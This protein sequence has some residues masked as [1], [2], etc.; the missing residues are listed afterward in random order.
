MEKEA[1]TAHSGYPRSLALAN[2]K[3]DFLD[4]MFTIA[5]I[6]V[7]VAGCDASDGMVVGGVHPIGITD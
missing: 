1:A 2:S 7:I 4:R 3:A 5:T 6:L